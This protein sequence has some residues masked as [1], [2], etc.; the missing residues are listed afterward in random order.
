[1]TKQQFDQLY[2]LAELAMQD[3][4]PKYVCKE[5]GV[6]ALVDSSGASKTCSCEAPIVVSMQSN[7]SIKAS[8][9]G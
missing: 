2:H 5:C 7:L 8:L 6:E 3:I 4:S 9:N 1:M